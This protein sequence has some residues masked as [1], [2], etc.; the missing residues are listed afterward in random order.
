[1]KQNHHHIKK[2]HFIHS[3]QSIVNQD[4]NEKNKIEV[5]KPNMYSGQMN[6]ENNY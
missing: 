4:R 2:I 3:N 1:M 5:P 6:N